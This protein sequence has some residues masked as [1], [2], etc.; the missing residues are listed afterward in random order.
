MLTK[1]FSAFFR[2]YDHQFNL[3]HSEDFK[4]HRP[5]YFM[6]I[7]LCSECGLCFRV[8]DINAASKNGAG[9]RQDGLRNE[10]TL[11]SYVW[12]KVRFVK[13]TIWFIA[14]GFQSTADMHKQADN[15]PNKEE[16]S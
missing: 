6:V 3:D 13:G 15:E 11:N 8:V 1:K 16:G 10:G 5:L 7:Q 2:R 14:P 4:N 12:V 9:C